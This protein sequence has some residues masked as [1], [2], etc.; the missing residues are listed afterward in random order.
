VSNYGPPPFAGGKENVTWPSLPSAV[1]DAAEADIHKSFG[2]VAMVFDPNGIGPDPNT[3]KRIAFYAFGKADPNGNQPLIRSVALDGEGPKT[4]PGMCQTCHSGGYHG[5]PD[6]GNNF[7]PF[8]VQG[9]SFDSTFYG[10]EGTIIGPSGLDM[11]NQQEAFR[12][13]NALVMK[14]NPTPA[15]Q[16]LI[17]GLYGGNVET[18]GAAVPDDSYIPAGWDVDKS[19]RNLYR[20]VYRP[21]CRTCHVAQRYNVDLD[22]DMSFPSIREFRKNPVRMH[23]VLCDLHSMPNAQVPYGSFRPAPGSDFPAPRSS[24]LW[25]DGVAQSDL[26]SNG[27]AGCF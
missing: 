18:P 25:T 13:L 1:F 10:N 19:S 16:N 7:L 26:R 12:R 14:T 21:Y 27:I 5:G 9:F 2:T 22:W 4:V 23:M 24:A 17:N 6:R 20:H 8:D 11:D 3:A 15:I